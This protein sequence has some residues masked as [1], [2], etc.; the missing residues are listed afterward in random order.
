MNVFFDNFT[1]TNVV[2]LATEIA[3]YTALSGIGVGGLSA[4]LSDKSHDEF[5][6]EFG[7]YIAKIFSL[8]KL[9]VRGRSTQGFWWGDCRLAQLRNKRRKSQSC[10]ERGGNNSIQ[11][12][13]SG[14]IDLI[15]C[16]RLV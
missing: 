16:I 7:E 3:V 9:G 14:L 2:F 1:I 5:L 8:N 10:L 12:E 11:N 15:D 4:L 13:A 6:R